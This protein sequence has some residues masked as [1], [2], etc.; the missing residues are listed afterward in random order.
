MSED[1]VSLQWGFGQNASNASVAVGGDGTIVSTFVSDSNVSW[2][3][4]GA[5]GQAVQNDGNQSFNFVGTDS[6]FDSGD[7]PAMVA[8]DPYGLAVSIHEADGTS[9]DLWINIGTATS[10]AG[11]FSVAAPYNLGVSG[12]QP[13]ILAIEQG[14]FLVSALVNLDNL[15]SANNLLLWFVTI[16]VS[17]SNAEVIVN[18]VTTMIT[19]AANGGA[20]D[21]PPVAVT[22]NSPTGAMPKLA[23]YNGQ[24]AVISVTW[25]DAEML[26]YP[27]G[28]SGAF[29]YDAQ[30]STYTYT[31]QSQISSVL[32]QPGVGAP[33]PTLSAAFDPDGNLYL[34]GVYLVS[35]EYGNS[36]T[37]SFLVCTSTVFYQ[38]NLFGSEF[39][40]PGYYAVA[41]DIAFI[42]ANGYYG[43]IMA[44]LSYCNCVDLFYF[45][46]Q[47]S[48]T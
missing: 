28:V 47:Q 32:G 11:N 38:E 3:I 40:L 21:D 35:S 15:E 43:I 16:K 10:G 2:A 37:V 20:A 18:P 22:L 42:N 30:T 24:L 4:S 27:Y 14:Q 48:Q 41:L 33:Q 6:D 12:Y 5:F 1:I 29:G 19:S 17:G 31:V 36:T 46:I 9:T 25:G 8:I 45:P 7:A 44:V 39:D 23:Y 13:A 34:A 26:V